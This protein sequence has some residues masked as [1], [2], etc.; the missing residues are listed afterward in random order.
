MVPV[1]AALRHDVADS[2]TPSWVDA[3]LEEVLQEERTRWAQA[4]TWLLEPLSL[5]A[6]FVL[7][8][9]KRLRPAF[10]WYGYLGA[11]GSD[12]S[13]VAD[14]AA[15]LELLH[16]FALLH[17]DVMDGSES[18]RGRPSMH[19]RLELD[20]CR[21]GW[22]GES[23]R[24]GEGMAILLGDLAFACAD[25]L[26]TG[27]GQAAPEV[28][29]VWN[30]LRLELVMGQYLDLAGAARGGVGWRRAVRIARLKS[31]AY[32]VERPLH[33]GAALTGRLAEMSLSYTAFG[34]PLGD[35]FQLRDD[36]VGAFGD[37]LLS[38][39]A[40]GA[41][42]RD[43]KPTLL[44]AVARDRCGAAATRLLDRVG[45]PDLSRAEVRRLCSLL[46]DCGARDEVE[47][48]IRRRHACAVAALARAP[49]P[50]HVRAALED[51]AAQVVGGLA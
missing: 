17:D 26:L 14:V 44:L 3:R 38:G 34:R 27:A 12:D 18:R 39:K 11:G 46:V 37:E 8:G 22:R 1:A 6:D 33:L 30:E 42:L 51:L 35:A 20:H 23:R 19:R 43:G 24:F 25:R 50:E 32:T 9:G 13:V 36:L 49:I 40:V 41:D 2:P 28:H 47:Q 16:A 29:G 15:A 48:L 31:G 5:L 7:Q 4:D 45:A 21:S 10:C